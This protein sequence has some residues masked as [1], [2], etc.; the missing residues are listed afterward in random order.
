MELTNI[1]T[2]FDRFGIGL[3]IGVALMVLFIYWK[4]HQYSQNKAIKQKAQKACETK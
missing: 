3:I 4:E 2:R 1:I